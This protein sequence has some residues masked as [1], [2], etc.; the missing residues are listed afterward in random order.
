V[1]VLQ[2]R[3]DELAALMQQNDDLKKELAE[4]QGKKANDAELEALR[5]EYQHRLRGGRAQGMPRVYPTSWPRAGCR[6]ESFVPSLSPNV[7]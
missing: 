5:E 3:A 4:A 7:L 1:L 2:A 6:H